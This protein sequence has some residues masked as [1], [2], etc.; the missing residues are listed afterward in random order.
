MGVTGLP[1]VLN[2]AA[3]EM[4][5]TFK[6]VHSHKALTEAAYTHCHKDKSMS[7]WSW[8]FKNL[9]SETL[10]SSGIF[11]LQGHHRQE[12]SNTWIHHLVTTPGKIIKSLGEWRVCG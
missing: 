6:Y 10:K 8:L 9:W 7:L 5:N 3:V 12:P 2:N 1:V 4:A 11:F